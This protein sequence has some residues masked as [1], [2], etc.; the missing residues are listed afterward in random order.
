[1]LSKS[2]LSEALKRNAQRKSGWCER[3]NILLC[4]NIPAPLHGVAPRVVLGNKWWGQTRKAAYAST[5]YHCVACGVYKYNARFRKHLEAHE[6]YTVDYLLGRM[7]YQETVPLCHSCHN[8]IHSGRL[9]TLLEKG[10]I[11]HS[12]FSA[13]I[14][15]GDDVLRRANLQPPNQYNG[16]VANWSNWRLVIDNKEYPPKFVTKAQHQKAFE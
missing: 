7:Y 11:S 5:S 2:K 3:P 9:A 15:H 4:P 16:P 8:Y 6:V 13:I 10:K 14:R 1:M 12:K